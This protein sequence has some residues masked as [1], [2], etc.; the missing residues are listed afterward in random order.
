MSC[1]TICDRSV[2]RS[3]EKRGLIEPRT[4]RGKSGLMRPVFDC[5]G[6]VTCYVSLERHPTKGWRRRG[7]HGM[8][9]QKAETIVRASLFGKMMAMSGN[10]AFL[11]L[12]KARRGKKLRGS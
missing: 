9:D 5:Y 8:A 7:G 2:R 12:P 4:K 3:M 1:H 11:R 10:G 6:N